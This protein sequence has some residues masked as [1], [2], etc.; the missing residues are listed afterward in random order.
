MFRC[1]QRM[2]W[3]RGLAAV[4]SLAGL[5]GVCG[6]AHATFSNAFVFG[7]P[8]TH[9]LV[10]FATYD[11]GDVKLTT[12]AGQNGAM[13]YNTKE[14]VSDGFT[15][16]FRFR[17][18]F[19]I[20]SDGDGFAF[21]LHNSFAGTATLGSGGGGIG[22][23]GIGSALAIEFDT[24]SCCGE[25]PTPNVA[26][27]SGG[28]GGVSAAE[29]AALAT[30]DL[31]ALGVNILD[32]SEHTGVVQY[33]PTPD[34]GV[35]PSRIDVYID[36]TLVLTHNIDLTNIAGDDITDNGDMYVGFTAGTGIAD[37]S[38]T[39]SA[40]A[41]NN[42]PGCRGPYWHLMSTYG[43]SD[44]TN[45]YMGYNVQAVGDHPMTYRWYRYG[46]E[47]TDDDAGRIQGLGTDSLD[48]VPAFPSDYGYYHV[49]FTNACGTSFGLRVRLGG[50]PADIDDGS[51]TGVPDDGVTIDDLLYYLGLFENGDPAADLDDGS[52]NGIGDGGVTID[53]LIY[54]L[55]RF[56]A[57]C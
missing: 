51:G 19:N 52:S 16:T 44:G 6:S 45:V 53:D 49:E 50:C 4:S 33:T 17:I 2:A 56:E 27:H 12:A 1:V 7:M 11:N 37:S 41:F 29:S 13:W 18:D 48:F 42:D 24:W 34:G 5:G 40:W 15:T 38:H 32:H 9:S 31:S 25:L 46:V 30:A 23:D 10:G 47:I 36:N 26:I 21:V 8:T 14:T 39:L 57:G 35:T 22:Y 28:L 43:G 3:A 20:D 54:F 55:T